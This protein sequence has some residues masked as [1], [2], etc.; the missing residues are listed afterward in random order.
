VRRDKNCQP[1]GKL[2]QIVLLL[3]SKINITRT[4]TSMEGDFEVA[5]KGGLVQVAQEREAGIKTEKC[6][7]RML[8]GASASSLQP[9]SKISAP[10]RMDGMSL[11]SPAA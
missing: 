10:P 5:V 8:G 6:Y 9:R 1:N 11:S 4:V 3:F 7:H 2:A